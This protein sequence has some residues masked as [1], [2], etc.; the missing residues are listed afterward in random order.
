MLD[1]REGDPVR[2]TSR[3]GRLR[4]A[5]ASDREHSARLL[6][7]TDALERSVRARHRHQSGHERKRLPGFPPAGTQILPRA[8]GSGARRRRHGA[9]RRV[10]AAT[11]VRRR[12][13]LPTETCYDHSLTSHLHPFFY[14]QPHGSLHPRERTVHRG[15]TSM[16]QRF[17]GRIVL[18][19]AAD[20]RRCSADTA[21]AQ[22]APTK[23]VLVM[24]GSQTGNAEGLAKKVTSEAGK[25]GL[26]PTLTDMAKHDTRDL[27]KES[28]PHRHEHLGRGRPARQRRRVLGKAPGRGASAPG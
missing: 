9:D 4:I 26:A 2:I 10:H 17:S 7:G 23:P 20:R 13:L 6:L 5:R 15:T 11:R 21:P 3:Q 8:P 24:F 28:S 1:V 25:R 18:R 19:R 12:S 16:A 22:A 14:V 27:Q